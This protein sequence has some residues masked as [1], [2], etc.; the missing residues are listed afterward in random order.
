MNLEF[1]PATLALLALT[2]AAT[3]AITTVGTYVAFRAAKEVGEEMAAP[4]ERIKL[5]LPSGE[6]K[7]PLL[8]HE[9]LLK[10]LE[11]AP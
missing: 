2:G 10:L 11:P 4:E 3:G 1:N 7:R 8:P 5:P 6:L 9:V